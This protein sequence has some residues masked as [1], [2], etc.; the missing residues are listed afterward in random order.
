MADVFTWSVVRLCKMIVRMLEN[1]FDCIIMIEGNRGLGKSTLGYKILSGIHK[2]HRFNPWRDLLYTRKEIIDAFNKRWKSGFIADEMINVSFNRDHYSEDQK[3][4]IKIVNMNRDHCNCFIACVPQ[5][6]VLDSQVKN[7]CKIRITVLRRGFAIIHTPNKTIFSSDKWDTALNEKIEKTW[8][9]HHIFKPKYSKLTTFRGIIKFNK[10]TE[11]QEEEYKRIKREKRNQI[12]LDDEGQVDLSDPTDKILQ[13][14]EEKKLT[15]R[16]DFDKICFIM[17]LKPLNVMQNIRNR[18][19][20]K[21]DRRGFKEWFGNGNKQEGGEENV[22][23]I[24]T[25]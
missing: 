18:L 10:L 7:L 6:S 11:K 24:F 12:M 1:D 23:K 19:R 20:Q 13:M 8:L 25:K 16:E 21:G 17:N 3:K 14:L 22:P 9:K 5:F 15:N 2:I 4:L